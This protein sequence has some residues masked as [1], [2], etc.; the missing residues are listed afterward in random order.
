MFCFLCAFYF[1]IF[2][3]SSFRY[4]FLYRFLQQKLID[5]CFVFGRSRV[6]ISVRKPAKLTEGFRGFSQPLQANTSIVP[7]NRPRPLPTAPFQIHYSLII[8]PLYSLSYRQHCEIIHKQINRN[9]SRGSS[10]GT[11]SDYGLD[12]R[13][14]IPDRGRGFF[15]YPLRPDRL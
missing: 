10:V 2:S 15:F 14:S 11:V 1:C 4:L 8:R 5:S 12:D 6:Q 3:F 9:G 7:Q 13:G